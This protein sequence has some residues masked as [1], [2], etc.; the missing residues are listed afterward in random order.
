MSTKWFTFR[1]RWRGWEYACSPELMADGMWVHLVSDRPADGFEELQPGTYLRLV[2]AVECDMV[3]H[4]TMT[5]QWRGEPCL[6]QDER[7]DGLLLEYTGGK[8][9]RALELGLERI[10]R[11]VYRGWVPREEVQ[12]L[13][14][15]TTLLVAPNN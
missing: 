10:E 9:P 14:E 6:V 7:D 13:R 12:G 15:N 11:G 2:A 8:V 3:A 4:V 1:A 5:C